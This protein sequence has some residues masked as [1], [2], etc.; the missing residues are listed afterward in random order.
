MSHSTSII[1]E[2]L[3]YEELYKNKYEKYVVLLQV[4]SFIIL[5]SSGKLSL[6]YSLKYNLVALSRF[7]AASSS[8]L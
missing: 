8:F 1:S 4:G 7:L 6:P 5:Y 2:Y 3:Q